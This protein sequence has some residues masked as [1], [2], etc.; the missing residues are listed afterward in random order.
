M[1]KYSCSIGL[2]SGQIQDRVFQAEST[3]ALQERLA[4]EGIHLF[5]S[6]RIWTVGLGKSEGRLGKGSLTGQ[7]LLELLQE[8]MVLLKSGLPVMEVIK[9]LSEGRSGT[10]RASLEEMQTSIRGGESLSEAFAAHPALFPRLLVASIR[11][12]EHTGDVPITLQRFIDHSKKM[13]TL[14]RKARNAA[15]YP[16]FLGVAAVVVLIFLLVK[17]VPQLS[18]V[19]LD[20]GVDL[21][22]MTRVV[23]GLSDW[24]YRNFL[25]LFVVIAL[26]LYG[27][28]R[29]LRHP[30]IGLAWDRWKL[31]IPVVGGLIRYYGLLCFFQTLGTVLISGMPLVRALVMSQDT[32]NNR[33][34]EQE[35]RQALESVAEGGRLSDA[36]RS[37]GEFPELS[38]RMIHAGENSGALQ[39]MLFE[40]AQHYEVQF[41]QGLT[42]LTTLIEPVMMVTIGLLV[43]F[44][45][46]AMYIPIFHLASAF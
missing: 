8:M 21:P 28:P 45:I 34:L 22:G 7:G 6:R 26:C 29:L 18:Q 2:P 37:T 23:I 25:A 11:A 42:R 36:F 27:V 1:P 19:F 43:G 46:V 3:V 30:R 4:S 24:V 17:V 20:S 13:E 44:M 35:V 39:E 14:T 40:L 33:H 31:R 15:V 16:A 5:S 32:L 10:V 38:L 41:D 9:G 12:G